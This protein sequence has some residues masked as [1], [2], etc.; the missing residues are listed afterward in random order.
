VDTVTNKDNIDLLEVESSSDLNTFIKVPFD[1]YRDDPNWVPPLITE[2]KD[3]FNKSKNPFFRSAKTRLFL[4]RKNSKYVG[5]I[6]ICV[7][8]SY[9]EFHEVNTGF[10]GFFD[11]VEDYEVAELLFKV[12]LIKLKAE[13]VDTMLGP[14]NF[15]T[16]H[17]VGMLIEGY[18][19]PPVVMMTYN[20]PYYNDFAEKFGLRKSKDLLA[21]R[22]YAD[23]EF[24]PRLIKMAERMKDREG[25]ELRTINM[26]RFDEEVEL[27]N[28][29]YNKAWAKNWGFVPL[30][31]E[32]FRHVA[33]DMKQIIDPDIVFVAEVNGKAVGFSLTLPD[34]NQ[35][36][37]YAN[38]RLFPT[39]LAKLLWHTKVKNKVDSVRI[40]TLG[41]LPEYQ[42]RGID[43]L[44]YLKTYEVAN[45]KGYKYG[46]MSWVL[47]D[48]FAM[49]RAG[50]LMGGE[51]Y[52]KYRIYGMQV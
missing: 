4:A 31:K 46:E 26:R 17:E 13:G 11:C 14:C 48:N 41:L 49:V 38:G 12:A 24:D 42:K 25:V 37:K 28:E 33:K 9:N 30:S 5:R 20:K 45:E 16:N 32:E 21:F 29:L 50:E 36:L 10:F 52:K 27:I 34:I 2:R 40:I 19:M 44:L 22:I 8:Y 3:F 23:R 47:E 15:S 39:G 43:T 6:A 51:L 35:A 1:I 7:N 18:D